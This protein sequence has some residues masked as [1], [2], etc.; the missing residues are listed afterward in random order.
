MTFQRFKKWNEKHQGLIVK[1]NKQFLAQQKQMF[2]PATEM[3]RDGASQTGDRQDE[4]V[5]FCSDDGLFS[6]NVMEP[7]ASTKYMS[8]FSKW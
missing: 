8:V 3:Q 2:Q 7:R 4:E 1:K 5:C 6:V